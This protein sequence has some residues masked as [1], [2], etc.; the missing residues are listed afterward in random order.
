[1]VRKEKQASI[2]KL[3]QKPIKDYLVRLNGAFMTAYVKFSNNQTCS[4]GLLDNAIL[5]LESYLQ[6]GSEPQS[7]KNDLAVAKLMRA[8]FF[9]K[10]A[11]GSYYRD[12]DRLL[13]EYIAE[14]PIDPNEIEM[15]ATPFYFAAHSYIDAAELTND[16]E[17]I[18][19][20]DK[21]IAIAQKG[22]SAGIGNAMKRQL[23][24]PLG[25]A[26]GNKAKYYKIKDESQFRKA[27]EES[28]QFLMEGFALG[29][30]LA[31]YNLAV[32]YSLLNDA[33]NSKKWLLV[34]E[35]RK[36]ADKQICLQGL[37][38]DPDLA[39]LRTNQKEWLITYFTRN[40]LSFLPPP[41]STGAP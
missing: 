29:D 12:A 15:I 32:D 30:N 34:I 6:S 21:A 36:A 38:L 22:R 3:K 31:A 16:D 41:S 33:E 19:L 8:S 9:Q 7:V 40:C 24:E 28:M 14:S 39:W 13:Q 1:M 4:I 37:L 2:D 20:L 10:G 26:L 11:R 17:K 23:S 5:I 25:V 35:D 27:I 18:I